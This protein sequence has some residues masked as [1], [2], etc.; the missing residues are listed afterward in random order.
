MEIDTIEEL[1]KM[2]NNTV[3]LAHLTMDRYSN[4]MDDEMSTADWYTLGFRD[5]TSMFFDVRYHTPVLARYDCSDCVLVVRDC[6]EGTLESYSIS[7]YRPDGWGKKS[8]KWLDQEVN[9]YRVTKWAYLPPSKS[10]KT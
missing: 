9:G 2:D 4:E 1:S 10:I 6:G 3:R 8:Y 5:G 7:R